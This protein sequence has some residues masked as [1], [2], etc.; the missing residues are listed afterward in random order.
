MAKELR[1]E[2]PVAYEAMRKELRAQNALAADQYDLKLV[3]GNRHREIANPKGSNK[4]EWSI[5]V[6]FQDKKINP[7]ELIEK[8]RFGLHP[9]FGAPHMDVKAPDHKGNY[10]MTFVGWGTFTIP[11]TI[12][13][14]RATGLNPRK[15]ELE[16]Y[17]SFD[18][19]GKWKTIAITINKVQA[20]KLGI[21]I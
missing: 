7:G 1:K 18:G 14:K 5:F 16:H 4:H 13:F 17:L 6:K 12:D 10:E 21:Q 9:T 20:R 2:D 15:L 3:F 8:V 19:V 11:I